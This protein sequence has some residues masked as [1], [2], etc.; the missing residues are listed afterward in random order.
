MG[1]HV[2]VSGVHGRY[3]VRNIWKKESY[4]NCL[5]KELCVKNM[6]E[7]REKEEGRIKILKKYEKNW[8]CVGKKRT[9]F[10]RFK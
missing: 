5:K 4:K 8:L 6:V 7:K 3:D 10:N 9:L 2:D 1:S